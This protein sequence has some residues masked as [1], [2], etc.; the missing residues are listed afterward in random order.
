VIGARIIFAF[1]ATMVLVHGQLPL[2]AWNGDE[3]AELKKEGW[4]AGAL[5]L[6]SDPIPEV[7]MHAEPL[8]VPLPTPEEVAGDAMPSN[9]VEEKFLAGYFA[10]RPT[11]FLVDP[12][13]LLTP[14]EERDRLSFLQ[15]HASDSAI[16]LFVY[17]L[18]GN[19]VI[20]SE[21][22]K[23]EMIERLF[24]EGR[25]AAIVYYYL[26]APQRSEVYLSRSIIGEIPHAEQR[27][28]LESSVIQAFEKSDAA[29]QLEKFLVQMSIRIYWMERLM[30][31]EPA[32]REAAILTD[33]RTPVAKDEN[34]KL[35]KLA[36]V[37]ALSGRVAAPVGVL[38]AVLLV[39]A[40]G[41][42]RWLR[43]RT[44]YKFPDFDVEPRLG[45]AHAAGIGAVISFASAAVPPASQRNQMPDYLR[46]TR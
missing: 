4:V 31:G 16:D 37:R 18:G 9:E 39:A 44:R 35:A 12:Q 21:V 25:P 41:M 27:R 8:N 28:A 46:R 34:G 15:Y 13:K 24:S 22:R 33:S 43:M 20:P 14:T 45:G 5:L 40:A 6:S 29:G 10:E 3:R 38:F 36:W 17:I 42:N 23:E 2:P 32:M 19:Q 26:G 7:P 11:S 1:S 30:N